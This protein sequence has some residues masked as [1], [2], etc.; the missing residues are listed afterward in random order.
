MN[1]VEY[2]K[3]LEEYH[4][5]IKDCEEAE[6]KRKNLDTKKI[7]KVYIDNYVFGTHSE[8]LIFG[9]CIGDTEDEKFIIFETNAKELDNNLTCYE[10]YE[11]DNKILGEYDD[12]EFGY[13][14]K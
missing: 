12:F 3:S 8:D 11:K 9:D 6:E 4:K 13:I 14:E 7:I 5:R 2:E 1:D 10:M